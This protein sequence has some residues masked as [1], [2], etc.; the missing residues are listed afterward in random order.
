MPVITH[1][2]LHWV[3]AKICPWS[4][5]EKDLRQAR[6][7]FHFNPVILDR[8]LAALN[9]RHVHEQTLHGKFPQPC[10]VC[11]RSSDTKTATLTKASGRD[12]DDPNYPKRRPAHKLTQASCSSFISAS[13]TLVS[14]SWNITRVS[15]VL[16]TQSYSDERLVTRVMHAFSIERQQIGRYVGL[17]YLI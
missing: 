16:N 14:N 8:N 17:D 2:H 7:R 9:V 13:V 3:P 6:N 5:A 4:T 12:L 1:K 11:M 10:V 15:W